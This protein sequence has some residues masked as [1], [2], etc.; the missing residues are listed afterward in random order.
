MLLAYN[1]LME[2]IQEKKLI[3][4]LGSLDQVNGTSVDIRLGPTFMVEKGSN[5]LTNLGEGEVIELQELVGSVHLSP[6]RFVLAHT[7]EKF[8]LPNNISAHF[9]MKSSVA[10]N[11]VSHMMAGHCNP[12]WSNSTLTLELTNATQHSHLLLTPGM[13]IGQMV[14]YAHDPVPDHK[15]YSKTGR[16]NNDQSVSGAKS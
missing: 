8:N 7:M 13:V 11:G 1:E 6:G 3:E 9:H 16:Y 15:L 12:G 14:F 4:N 10:R 5:K 2:L